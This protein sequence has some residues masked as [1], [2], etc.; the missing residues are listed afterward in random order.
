[1]SGDLRVVDAVLRVYAGVS[2]DA[3]YLHLIR[4]LRESDFRVREGQ[5][6]IGDLMCDCIGAQSHGSCYRLKEA[7]ALEAA[8]A[9]VEAAPSWLREVAPE[10]ELEKA[11]ARG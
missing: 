7:I 5:S 1:M 9:D 4:P 3:T 8:T 2:R 11:A 10:T 6:A